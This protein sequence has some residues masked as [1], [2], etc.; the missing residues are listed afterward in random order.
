MMSASFMIRRSSPSILTSVPDHLPNS[1]RIAG[2][3]VERHQLAAFVARAGADG[4]HFAF[5]RLFLRGVG[6]DD[7]ALGFDIAFGAPDDD[8]VV[9]WPEF[10]WGSFCGRRI[11]RP[12][13]LNSPF[14][15]RLIGVLKIFIDARKI[16]KSMIFYGRNQNP[17]RT[18]K[19]LKN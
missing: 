7:P 3:D 16:F 5:L 13:R 11:G 4:D 2:L 14:G 8:A 10:H 1:M 18:L 17:D 6:N 15:T 12:R 19:T 9:K